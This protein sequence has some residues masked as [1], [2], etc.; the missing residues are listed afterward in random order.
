MA[1][2]GELAGSLSDDLKK[3]NPDIEWSRIR[4]LRNI[5]DHNYGSVKTDL[6]W[7]VLTVRVPELKSRCLAIIEDLKR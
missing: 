5:I 7:A 4:G 2:I 3:R 1:Q 6:M